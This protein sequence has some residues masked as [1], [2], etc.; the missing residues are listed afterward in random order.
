MRIDNLFLLENKADANEEFVVI[1]VR[2]W[3]LYDFSGLGLSFGT[4]KSKNSVLVSVNTKFYPL[5]LTFDFYF[6]FIN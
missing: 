4:Q 2:D 3:Y 5:Y 6:I 1:E